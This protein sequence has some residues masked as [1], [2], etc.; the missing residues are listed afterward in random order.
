[1][2]AASSCLWKTPVTPIADVDWLTDLPEVL[3]DLKTQLT[4]ANG[5]IDLLGM[6]TVIWQEYYEIVK[7][8]LTS[9][10]GSI[11]SHC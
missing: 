11:D 2:R 3:R 7:T 5:S 10:K 9:A 6:L 1:M 4:P 8:Q